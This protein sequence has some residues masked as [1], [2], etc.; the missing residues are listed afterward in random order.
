VTG[1]VFVGYGI[2]VVPRPE[3]STPFGVF[4]LCVVFVTPGAVANDLFLATVTTLNDLFMF[5]S[6]GRFLR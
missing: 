4:V 5:I 6:R 1:C 2:T 3:V